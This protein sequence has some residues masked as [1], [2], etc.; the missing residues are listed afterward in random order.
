MNEQETTPVSTGAASPR[1]VLTAERLRELLDY[2]QRSGFTWKKRHGSDRGTNIFNAKFAGKSAGWVVRKTGLRNILVD[3]YEYSTDRLVRL[4]ETGEL[5]EKPGQFPPLTGERLPSLLI[6]SPDEGT[7]IWRERP[8]TTKRNKYFNARFAGKP[9]GSL[10]SDGYLTIGLDDRLHY[11]HRLAWLY[12]TDEFPGETIDHKDGDRAN[13]KW[14]NLRNATR[15]QNNFNIGLRADN[16]SGHR[17]VTWYARY[18][19]WR[20]TVKRANVTHSLGYFDK[21]EDAIAARQAAEPKFYGE[22]ARRAP[23]LGAVA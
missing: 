17:G 22:F 19:K 20:A 13:N 16:S 7:F 9:A 15:Q 5:D 1:P 2:D 12:M 11:G 10:N 18:G 14:S 21:I 4:L 6:Y 3:G 8:N 23:E